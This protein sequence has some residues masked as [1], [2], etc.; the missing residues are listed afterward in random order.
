MI[1]PLLLKHKMHMT[2]PPRMSA[3]PPQHL[4]HRPII[5]DTIR[6]RHNRLEP[7]H[8]LLITMHHSPLIRPLSTR[9]LHIIEA[10]AVRFPNID[11]D[12][13]DWFAVCVFDVAEDE[14][15]FAVGV[16]GDDAAVWCDLG[17]VGVEG[18]EDCAFCALGW[19]GVVYAVDEEGEAEDVRE[20]D[21][22]L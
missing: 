1:K 2:R 16:V 12:V 21:E 15:G 9:I 3:Q 19:F 5:R 20:E 13:F 14:A 11:L 18:A 7:K 6:H 17:F 10:L 8:T 22:F 4:A